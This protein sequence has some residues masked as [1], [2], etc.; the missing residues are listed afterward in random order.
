MNQIVSRLLG[1]FE[2]ILPLTQRAQTFAEDRLAVNAIDWQH[3][4]VFAVSENGIDEK[5]ARSA[6][7][8]P[9]LAV[10]FEK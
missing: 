8:R 1:H 10:I 2:T 3:F 6:L 5:V 7:L 4:I 9:I